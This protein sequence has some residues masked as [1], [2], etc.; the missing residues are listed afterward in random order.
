[1]AYFAEKLKAIPGR[2]RH[3]AGPLADP[4]RHATWATRISISTTTCRTSW[5]AAPAAS[6]KGGRH[7][8]YERKTVHDRQPAA[9]HPGHVRHPPGAAG[10]QHGP[11]AANLVSRCAASPRNVSQRSAWHRLASAGGA[12]VARRRGAASD[13]ADAVMSGDTAAVRALLQQKADVNAPQV[14]GATALHWAV[15]RDDVE[16][17]DLLLRAGANVDVANRDGRDAAGDGVALR[18][19]RD[20]RAAARRR[21]RM[22]RSAARTAKRR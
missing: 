22:R 13:V 21:A 18:Q 1:M 8:A 19:R 17:A 14:D 2:R 5:S 9:E 4:L 11:P 16:A 7:L 10:R 12:A 3:A 6:C 15:Y 20:D